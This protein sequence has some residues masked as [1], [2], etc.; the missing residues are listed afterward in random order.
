MSLSEFCQ[1]YPADSSLRPS[2]DREFKRRSEFTQDAVSRVVVLAD[3]LVAA[4]AAGLKVVNRRINDRG[5]A[6]GDYRIDP[7]DSNLMAQHQAAVVFGITLSE[8]ERTLVNK[9]FSVKD[10]VARYNLAITGTE[11]AR[12]IYKE[13][14][15]EILTPQQW[16]T[17]IE[18]AK[19]DLTLTN[20]FDKSFHLLPQSISKS[21]EATRVLPVIRS[22]ILPLFRERA[23][24]VINTQAS[25]VAA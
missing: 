1:N 24:Q 25:S 16:R 3:A 9:K 20:F 5:F 6:L 17:L 18:G 15:V 22:A 8:I 7:V 11:L 14:G 10:W 23:Q 4:G 12:M 2:I 13:P 21:V 19:T